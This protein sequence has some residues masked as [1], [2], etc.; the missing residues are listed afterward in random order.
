MGNSCSLDFLLPL[1]VYDRDRLQGTIVL[2][3]GEDGEAYEGVGNRPVNLA[4]RFLLADD[5]GPF[6]SPITDSRRTCIT[7][8]TASA[9]V[10]I[11]APATYEACVLEAHAR[12]LA[13]RVEACCRGRTSGIALKAG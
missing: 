7:E 11:Y 8:H 1:G 12:T 13:E 3:Q 10:L 2:R 5:V 6:G 4:G 9:V